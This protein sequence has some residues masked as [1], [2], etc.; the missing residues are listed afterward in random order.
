VAG[1]R[2]NEALARPIAATWGFAEATLFFVVPDVALTFLA[3]RFRRIAFVACLWAFTGALVGG[4]VMYLWGRYSPATAEMVLERVPGVDRRMILRVRGELEQNGAWAVVLGPL[5][6]TPYKI[7]AVEAG[8]LGTS[9][10][11]VLAAS[12]PSRLGRFLLAT[13][14][15]SL[16]VRGPFA[17]WSLDRQRLAVGLFWVA[18]Y[19]V[20]MLR[21]PG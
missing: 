15:V 17:R 13:L 12:F 1:R 18:V 21:S 3:L 6:T 14:G 9:P 19:L 7:Y 20:L 11:T 2:G 16:L 10:L 4:A 8:S 5:K